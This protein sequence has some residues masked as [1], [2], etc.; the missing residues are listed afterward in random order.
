MR[1][2]YPIVKVRFHLNGLEIVRASLPDTRR[3]RGK[4]EYIEKLSESSLSKLAFSAQ[5][6]RVVFRS[7]LCL[8][9][10][11][12]YPKNGLIFKMALNRV[13]SAMRYK[14]TPFD[15]LWFLEFQ[16]RGAPHVHILTSVKSPT[17]SDRKWLAERWAGSLLDHAVLLRS[18]ETDEL[19][20]AR[21][22][23]VRQH[24]RAKTWEKIRESGGAKRYVTKYAT[25]TEQKS[26]P[27]SFANVGRFWSM[28][29]DASPKS[30]SANLTTEEEVRIH[31][32]AKGHPVAEWDV[33]PRLIW[34]RDSD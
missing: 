32:R 8:S 15:Y 6:S 4:R 34:F 24:R 2:N 22:K 27:P 33:L 13:L 1:E 21:N 31:L 14:F 9:C 3:S 11:L 18:Y 7:M 17:E 28:S 26:V 30:T 5:N 12:I 20:Q 16:K 19:G 10:G 23:M 25:K 29:R